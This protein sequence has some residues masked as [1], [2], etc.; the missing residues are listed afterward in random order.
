[1]LYSYI[2]PPQRPKKLARNFMVVWF[3]ASER[4]HARS[5]NNII[6]ADRHS[7]VLAMH[8]CYEHL[9][10]MRQAMQDGSDSEISHI[11]DMRVQPRPSITTLRS[12]CM[13]L[14]VPAGTSHAS[15]MVT[16]CLLTQSLALL[17]TFQSLHRKSVYL[18]F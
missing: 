7:V 16:L 9:S 3:N 1:L 5:A 4:R 13:V 18:F 2:Q 11:S 14:I 15:G 17:A 8:M 12:A 6:Q 10:E